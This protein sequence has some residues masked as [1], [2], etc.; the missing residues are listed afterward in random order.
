MLC[1]LH[2]LKITNYVVAAFDPTAYT[3][4]KKHGLSCFPISTEVASHPSDTKSNASIA[5]DFGTTAF[6]ALTKLKSQQ[7]LRILELGYS[8]LWSDVDIF[9]KRNPLPEL[10]SSMGDAHIAIQSNAP[11]VEA[12]SNGMRRINSGFY[13]ARH[14]DA[15]MAA[16]R[17]IVAHAQS[18]TLSEQPSFYTVLCGTE[19]RL[20]HMTTPLQQCDDVPLR[21]QVPCGRALN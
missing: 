12:P 9:W 2:S 10:L 17:Q 1:R 16:F 19:G 6:R 21:P 14:S 13:F 18:T 3:F 20:R 7:V 4:C 5:H 15:T 11:P 8:V